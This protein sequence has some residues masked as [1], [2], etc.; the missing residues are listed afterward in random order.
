MEARDTKTL[1][2]F[3]QQSLIWEEQKPK[4]ESKTSGSAA[5]GGSAMLA[6]LGKQTE[7]GKKH[8]KEKVYF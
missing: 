3:A 2:C 5:T 1:S 7:K 4:N 6:L 8:H